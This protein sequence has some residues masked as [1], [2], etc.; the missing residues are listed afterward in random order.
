[1]PSRAIQ[2][3]LGTP[4]LDPLVVLLRETGQNA[5][6]A[7]LGDDGVVDLRYRFENIGSERIRTLLELLLPEPF[8]GFAAALKNNPSLLIVSDR[9]TTGLGGPV[10]SDTAT[11]DASPDFVNFVRNVGE[12]RDRKHGGGTYGF[13]RPYH[14]H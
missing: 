12:A 10:R 3:Q 5:W 11:D 14:P 7:R 1:M 9:G 2:N 4:A 8:E 6:D 13:G